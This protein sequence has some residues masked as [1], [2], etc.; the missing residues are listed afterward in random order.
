[1]PRKK[2]DPSVLKKTV[3]E[4]PAHWMAVETIDMHT[5][6]EPLRIITSGLPEIKGDTIL[7]KRRFFRDNFDFLRTGLMWEPRGH[8]DMYG[9]VISGPASPEADFGVF[10]MHNEGYSTMC[11]H[12]IIALAKFAVETGLVKKKGKEQEI[13][14][15][16]PAG[17]ITAKARINRGLVESV[18]FRNVPSFM[19]LKNQK[20]IIEDFGIVVFNVAFGG[21]FYAIVDTELM[22]I[23][24]IPENINQFID[25]GMKI[26][27]G[28]MANYPIIHPFEEDLS[29]LYGTIFTGPAEKQGNHSRNIC[30]FA[31][32]EVDRSATGTGV[33]ARA[34]IHYLND[35]LPAGSEIVIESIIGTTMK[36]KVAEETMFGKYR[37][38]IP[39]VTGTASFTGRHRFCFDPDDPLRNG[40][41]LR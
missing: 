21:A 20:V 7:E 23:S 8:A 37:A 2:T 22:S 33:S 34:A 29:F 1:M 32:G 16:T 24:L 10:F 4:P 19:L 5:G 18:S 36:V 9:A 15:D 30:I 35:G 6:G 31:G 13:V 14:I 11:G 27:K 28:V 17:L 40:F 38:V 26:K 25:L 39:E 3:W 41:L 12:A